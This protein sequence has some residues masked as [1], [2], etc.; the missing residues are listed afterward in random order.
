MSGGAP[1]CDCLLGPSA[2]EAGQALPLY[3]L[4]PASLDSFR[5]G[6]REAGFL[7][8]MGFS[9]AAG[10]L[11]VGPGAT[12][13]LFAALGLGREQS[14]FVYGALASALPEGTT[15]CFAAPPPD[16]EAAI[17]GFA[18]GA[19]HYRKFT[20]SLRRPVRLVLP[21]A[22]PQ[23]ALEQ[24]AATWMVRDLINAPANVLGPEELAEAAAALGRRYGA[25]VSLHRGEA[26]GTRYPALAAVGAG[27]DRP[28]SV[29][30]LG[31]SGPDAG[32]E[33]P[34]VALCGK[35]V[36]FDSGGLDVKPAAGMLRMKKDMGGAAIALGVARLVMA[37]ELPVRLSVRIGAVENSISGRAMRPLDIIRTRHG[38]AVEIGNTDAEGRLVL[39]D[40]LAEAAQENPALLVDFATLTGAAR[41]AL[42]PDLPALFCSD[43]AWAE[44]LL[45]AGAEVHDPLWR[46][47]LWDGYASWLASPI[48]DLNTVST[49]PHAGAVIAALFLRRFVTPGTPWAH[50]DVYAWNDE[51]RPGRPEGGEAQAMRAVFRAL[52][53][54]FMGGCRG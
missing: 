17:F 19:Y 47:P 45:A 13:G 34:L 15:W 42:G 4:Q 3:T 12:G 29:V 49:R 43:D 48:A 41:V 46:L 23:S 54:H 21:A 25:T 14:P 5:P 53:R 36:C 8:E 39:A 32:Q 50:F 22:A 7:R 6:T 20:K 35:G 10:E 38:L 9:A 11:V 31:W 51:T 37:A 27:S 24:A 18:A 33:S 1:D 52:S 30:H 16:P 28:P 26:L 2:P 40:L 44:R